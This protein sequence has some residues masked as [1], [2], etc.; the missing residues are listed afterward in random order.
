MSLGLFLNISSHSASYS[1]TW[2]LGQALAVV[3]FI[4]VP[5]ITAHGEGSVL[6]CKLMTWVQL[7]N[8]GEGRRADS[9]KLPSDNVVL[10]VPGHGMTT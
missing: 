6:P 2:E 1:T 7:Q 4:L 8:P 5:A 10:S 3:I 9:T